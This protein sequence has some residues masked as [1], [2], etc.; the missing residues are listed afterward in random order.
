MRYLVRFIQFLIRALIGDKRDGGFAALTACSLGPLPLA[1]SLFHHAHIKYKD[2]SQCRSPRRAIQTA[3]IATTI[4]FCLWGNAGAAIVLDSTTNANGITALLTWS[5]T[6]GMGNS[7]LLIVGTAHRDGNMSVTSVTYGGTA[8]TSIGS[9]NGPGNQNQATL[10]YLINPPTGT[11][12][13]SVSLSGSKDV[14]AGAASFTGV[15]QTTPLGTLNSLS[16]TSTTAS[17][18][19]SSAAGEVVIDAVAAN[20]DAVSLTAAGGQ[21]VLWNIGTGTAGGNV[22]GG[23]SNQPGA[24]SVTMSWTLAASKP[25]AIGAISLKPASDICPGNIVTTTLDAINGSLSGSLRACVIKA[26]A[27]PGSTITVPAGTY[28][29]SVPGQNEDA[30]ATGDLDITG[31]MTI[32]GAGANV[33]IVDGGGLDRVF[34]VQK[35]FT[36]AITGMTIRN[37]NPGAANGGGVLVQGTLT[38]TDVAVNGNTTTG[39]GGGIY[40]MKGAL[41]LNRVT[42]SNNTSANGGGIGGESVTGTTLM[43]NVTVNGN[44]AS[45]SGGGFFDK[46]N[47]DTTMNNVTIFNNTCVG[48]GGG[49]LRNSGIINLSNTIVAF[50]NPV[51]CAGPITSN[52]NNLDNTTSC[53]FT[54]AGDLLNTNPLLG[55]LQNNGGT[56]L[57]DALSMGS[58]AIDAGNNATCAAVD[59]R[60]VA[61]PVD[62][63]GDSI[64]TC[65]MGAYEYNGAVPLIIVK[66]A[67]VVNGSAPLASP[68][69]AAVGSTLVFLIYVKNTTAATAT[70]VRI[71]DLLD[72]TGFQ[73]VVG[74]LVRTQAATPPADTA[75]DLQ[76]FNATAGGTGTVLTDGVDGDV[77]SGVDTGGLAGI[78]RITIGAVTGQAN[79]TLNISAHTTFAFRFQVKVK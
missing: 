3:L 77:A 35:N 59:E 12:N 14:T 16:G 68:A 70:D 34:D 63:N 45:Q 27:N 30:A 4:L 76:I 48:A 5:H 54:A 18:V 20:G 9:Q 26:N 17:V 39:D 28:I 38:L 75:T 71:N 11:A 55:P 13:I 23:S 57:T 49:I 33:T 41:T 32:N 62:G 47:F 43:T 60:G 78:D 73:Y 42:I 21:S 58:P 15:N 1:S 61:R 79:G 64:A 25:W 65:D 36:A 2:L 74:S 56:L 50:N 24:S 31:N 44:S 29:L 51:N 69:S 6:V 10:W 7:R 19:V 66:Q 67:W 72:E 53:N 37:G 52:G 40:D 22:R 8:L 46:K